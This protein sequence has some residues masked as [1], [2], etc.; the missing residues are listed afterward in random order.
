MGRR[1]VSPGVKRAAVAR[2]VAGSSSL[3]EE[4]NRTGLSKSTLHEAVQDLRPKPD[5]PDAGGAAAEP[6]DSALEA[7]QKAIGISA[8]D[9]KRP[10]TRDEI[11][12]AGPDARQMDE[13]FCV[14]TLNEIKTLGVLGGGLAQGIPV[15]SEKRLEPL[16]KMGEMAEG[17]TRTAAPELAPLLRKYLPDG[18]ALVGLALVLVLDAGG[19]F[20]AMRQIAAEHQARREEEAK[21][22]AE[23]KRTG[24]AA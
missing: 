18:S 23:M 10:L 3:R 14:N 4:A 7:A 22:K 2:V 13:E 5:E 11:L 16:C 12:R 6:G 20:L 15:L 17:A 19:T 1:K 24:E 8:E 9:T 21:K